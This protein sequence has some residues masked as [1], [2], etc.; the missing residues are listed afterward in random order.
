VLGARTSATALLRSPTW[1]PM[2]RGVA[3]CL[4]LIAAGFG[5]AL[6]LNTRGTLSAFLYAGQRPLQVESMPASLLW[7]G[8]LVGIP[9]FPDY[10]FVSLNYVGALDGVLRPLSAVA[11][12][13]GCALVYWRQARGKLGVGRAFLACLAIVLVTNK[14]FSP[15]YLI[16]LLPIVAYVEGFDLLWVVICLLTWLDFP[17][18]YQQRHPIITVPY[19]PL[20]MPE[21][22]LRNGLLLWAAAR[23]IIAPERAAH[24]MSPQHVEAPAPP[25]NSER[26]SA[27]AAL[28]G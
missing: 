14:I 1:R 16:W 10:S 11:L 21:V 3:L 4:T 28:S 9:A 12:V 27:S 8:T 23:A 15:Q 6:A 13:A 24:V 2:L 5:G 19:N 7:L 26:G 20:F 25:A 22:A 18:I 17:I